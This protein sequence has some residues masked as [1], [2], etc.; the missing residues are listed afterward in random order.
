MDQSTP[1]K[2]VDDHPEPAPMSC[3]MRLF[4]GLGDEG[5]YLPVWRLECHRSPH[6]VDFQVVCLRAVHNTNMSC[7]VAS[8]VS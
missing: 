5:G 1:G 2:D 8:R 3:V 6:H 4:C 7:C